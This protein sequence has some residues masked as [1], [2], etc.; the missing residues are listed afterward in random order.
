MYVFLTVMLAAIAN[1]RSTQDLQV[2]GFA[3]MSVAALHYWTGR[4]D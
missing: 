2:L 1:N 3:I 4:H